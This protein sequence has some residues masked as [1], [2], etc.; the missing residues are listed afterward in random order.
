MMHQQGRGIKRKIVYISRR[1]SCVF[2]SQIMIYCGT[3]K[4][5][6]S[7]A[8]LDAI[9]RWKPL[10]AWK[11]DLKTVVQ[12]DLSKARTL[13]LDVMFNVVVFTICITLKYFHLLRMLLDI[14][15]R[16]FGRPWRVNVGGTCRGRLIDERLADRVSTECDEHFLSVYKST[17]FICYW[18]PS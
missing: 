13:Y 3:I 11:P 16:A 12:A 4:V 6:V 5:G 9:T 1:V 18:Q 7:E 15:L 17:I 10:V 14:C 2:L 8:E